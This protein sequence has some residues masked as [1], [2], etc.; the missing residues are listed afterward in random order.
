MLGRTTIEDRPLLI[1]YIYPFYTLVHC[2]LEIM[3]LRDEAVVP[4][5]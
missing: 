2:C 1:R 3:L 5:R 4:E